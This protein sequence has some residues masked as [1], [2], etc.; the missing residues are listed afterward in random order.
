MIDVMDAD[1]DLVR[2]ASCRCQLCRQ[3]CLVMVVECRQAGPQGYDYLLK[4]K[5]WT[6]TEDT[7]LSWHPADNAFILIF[8]NQEAYEEE[9]VS[10]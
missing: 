1:V 7:R 5:L 6:L 3:G 10:T 2:A 9:E 8:C 4:L